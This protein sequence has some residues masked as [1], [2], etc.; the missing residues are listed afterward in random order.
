MKKQLWA[1]MI[2]LSGL[3]SPRPI[4]VFWHKT[5]KEYYASDGNFSVAFDG[6]TRTAC[7]VTFAH[8]NKMMVQTWI[9][10]VRSCQHL[11]REWS[12]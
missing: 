5:L 7:I 1:A 12:R 8:H 11:L 6:L 4:R 10:G 9:D 2:N 3:Y